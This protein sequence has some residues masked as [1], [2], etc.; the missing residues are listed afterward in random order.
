MFE[1]AFPEDQL[2]EEIEISK[3]TRNDVAKSYAIVLRSRH[4]N[5][6]DWGKVNR[7]IIERWSSHALGWIKTRAWNGR[8]FDD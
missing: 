3:S 8:C 7:A 2:L 6:I 5:S 4:R 1:F